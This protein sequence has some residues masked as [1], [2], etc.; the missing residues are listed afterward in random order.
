MVLVCCQ[1]RQRVRVTIGRLSQSGSAACI[2]LGK[3][4]ET[5]PLALPFRPA[6]RPVN[7]SPARP[8][9]A[10]HFF[11]AVS[12]RSRSHKQ[13]NDAPADAKPNS[14]ISALASR[15]WLQSVCTRI[16]IHTHTHT[17]VYPHTRIFTH[18]RDRTTCPR[19][20][21]EHVHERRER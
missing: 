11:F 12:A 9:R 20:C 8:T 17:H 18:T 4:R 6:I 1:C 14:R 7:I 19:T 10:G 5:P 3:N 13:S 21:Y 15:Q 2:K 16:A